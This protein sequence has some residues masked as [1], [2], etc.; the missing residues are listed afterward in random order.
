MRFEPQCAGRDGRIK[1]GLSPPRGFIATA[2]DFTMVPSTQWYSELIA[3][4][5]SESPGLGEA[6]MMRVGRAATADK[7]RLLG[8]MADMLA[9]ADATRFS[10]EQHTLVDAFRS[11]PPFRRLSR[12]GPMRFRRL[13]GLS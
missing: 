9:I 2:V 10:Q 6:Q 8:D 4:F 11:R 1:P 7:T 12:F 13:S 5:T 3:D